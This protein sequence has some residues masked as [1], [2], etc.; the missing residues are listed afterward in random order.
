MR[1]LFVLEYYYPHIGGVEKLFKLLCEQLVVNGHEVTVLTNRYK[2]D[3]PKREVIKGV[4][5]R[6]L[7][8]YNRYLFTFFSLP[9]VWS[10][11]GKS[12]VIHT[13]S[14]NAA[15]PAYF[16]ARLRKKPVY[17]TF[18]EAWGK[19]WFQLP[20]I[21]RISSFLFYHYERFILQLPFTKFIAVSDYTASSL[22][23]QGV[24][25]DRVI[26]I[27]NGI[28]YD[29]FPAKS[30]KRNAGF[31]FMY[32]GRLG[33]S[34]G[35]DLLIPAAIRFLKSNPDARFRLVVPK[36]K[37]R[38]LKYVQQSLFESNIFS[39]VEILHEL[40]R[41]ELFDEIGSAHCVVIPSY[42]EGFCFAAAET[43]ALGTPLISSDQGALKE[44]VSG[45]FIKMD[46]LT[47]DALLNALQE[48]YEGKWSATEIKKFRLVICI[49]RYLEFYG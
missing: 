20:F 32:F 22:I 49:N 24:N 14:Y 7:S 13:T 29:I 45:K 4:E 46:A 36:E 27:Y 12:D 1:I 11:A 30:Q 16:A 40:K 38:I 28:E 43:I 8:F 19:L 34:K 25:P 35:L 44:V 31:T 26:R 2:I 42:S 23:D 18:H 6:R 47:P 33:A 21:S 15:F 41:D 3:L 17:I 39:Q 9:I 37:N 10:Y 5:V 48:A